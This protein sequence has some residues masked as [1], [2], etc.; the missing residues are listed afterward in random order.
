VDDAELMRKIA[1][2]DRA[3]LG[4]LYDR[5]AKLVFRVAKRIL[6]D[7]DLAEDVLQDVYLQVWRRAELY[8]PDRG[9]AAAWLARLARNRSLDI[10]RKNGREVPYTEI[11]EQTIPDDKLMQDGLHAALKELP[12]EWME[13][14]VLAYFADMSQVQIAEYLNLPLGTVKSR[15]RAGLLKL[16]EIYHEDE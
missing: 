16:K 5:H 12:H 10:L 1:E 8:R 6:Q 7:N 11:L 9:Q 4:L 13:V 3:S 14:L 2:G 15:S